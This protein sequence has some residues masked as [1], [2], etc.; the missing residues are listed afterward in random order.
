M[1]GTICVDLIA[2]TLYSKQYDKKPYRLRIFQMD[3]HSF[4]TKKIEANI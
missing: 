2:F 3:V 4:D 1:E